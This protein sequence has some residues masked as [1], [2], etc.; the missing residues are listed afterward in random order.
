MPTTAPSID[1]IIPSTI[2]TCH[3]CSAEV[4]T[5]YKYGTYCKDVQATYYSPALCS[6]ECHDEMYHDDRYTATIG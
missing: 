3:W 6:V 4:Y 5:T 2:G 1:D